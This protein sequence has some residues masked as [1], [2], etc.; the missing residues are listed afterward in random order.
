M[1]FHSKLFWIDMVLVAAV[2]C[3][4]FVKPGKWSE[5]L[6]AFIGAVFVI[7]LWNHI[8]YYILFKKFY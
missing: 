3:L 5:I 2:L 8:R 1:N 4:L 7:S 6:T